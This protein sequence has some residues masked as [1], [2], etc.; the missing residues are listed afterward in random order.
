MFGHTIFG[1]L[2]KVSIHNLLQHLYVSFKYISW[3]W[4]DKTNL[5]KTRL[6]SRKEGIREILGR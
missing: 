1:S 2:S 4:D 6:G 5:W 3:V